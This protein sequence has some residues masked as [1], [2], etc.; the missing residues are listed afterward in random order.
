MPRPEAQA[1]LKAMAARARA[2][3]AALSDVVRAAHPQIEPAFLDPAAR[4]GQAPEEARAFA[5]AVRG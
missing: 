3:G 5:R 1:A 4:L 2:S